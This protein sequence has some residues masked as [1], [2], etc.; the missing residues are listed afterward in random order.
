MILK[1][2]CYAIK[3]KILFKT[4]SMQIDYNLHKPSQFQFS[5][6]N[7]L[8]GGWCKRVLKKSTKKKEVTFL[9]GADL[10]Q[11]YETEW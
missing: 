10:T 5:V 9:E 8:A 3:N 1:V 2:S 7:K 6:I 4:D 11:D